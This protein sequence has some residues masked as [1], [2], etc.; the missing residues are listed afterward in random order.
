MLIRANEAASRRLS[1]A[2]ESRVDKSGIAPS[3][4][5]KSESEKRER[6]RGINI[7][8][9]AA[10]ESQFKRPVVEYLDD[11]VPAG[12]VHGQ[13]PE[14][15]T[16]GQLHGLARRGQQLRGGREHP[17]PER[18]LMNARCCNL[19]SDIVKENEKVCRRIAQCKEIIRRNVCGFRG[20]P[21]VESWLRRSRP[22]FCC[23][24]SEERSRERRVRNSFFS[25]GFSERVGEDCVN[26]CIACEQ[27]SEHRAHF[28]S[29]GRNQRRQR[30]LRS[31]SRRILSALWRRERN[32][33]QNSSHNS[34]TYGSIRMRC[35]CVIRGHSAANAS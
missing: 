6:E 25:S 15:Q 20:V 2:E 26:E 34:N 12:R 7:Y 9:Y 31:Y 3:C 30:A 24:N 21:A 22:S 18:R 19:G 23:L 14:A 4:G 35:R 13:V 33:I 5:T 16:G 32:I 8:I 17:G 28:I 11:D 27:K 29:I 1:L 10:S